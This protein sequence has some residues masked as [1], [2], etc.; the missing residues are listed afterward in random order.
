MKISVVT[1]KK[2]KYKE[3]NSYDKWDLIFYAFVPAGVSLSLE[4]S[5]FVGVDGS[6]LLD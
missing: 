4:N 3:N 1:I 5:S 2:K 6:D